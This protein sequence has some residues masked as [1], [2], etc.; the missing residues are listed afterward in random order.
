MTHE[1]RRPL[2]RQSPPNH[3]LLGMQL[4]PA[5][6]LV[7]ALRL[8]VEW[9]ALCEEA[10]SDA[11]LCAGEHNCPLPVEAAAPLLRLRFRPHGSIVTC[12]SAARPARALMSRAR[13]AVRVAA[14]PASVNSPSS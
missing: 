4:I 7:D 5:E 12:R 8:L 6:P 9:G 10:A 3:S 1:I 11:K 2:D 13:R 14:G